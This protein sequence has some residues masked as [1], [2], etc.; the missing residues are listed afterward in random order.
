MKIS[1]GKN[2]DHDTDAAYSPETLAHAKLIYQQQLNTYSMLARYTGKI[3]P[4]FGIG[5]TADDYLVFDL[6]YRHEKLIG[7]AYFN[8]KISNIFDQEI[9]Y[10]NNK[11]FNE[12][13]EKGTIGAERSFYATLGWRF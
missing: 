9:R 4:P 2:S 5:E 13:L 3:K 8:L 1:D 7:Q 12:R 11:E 6:N 10:P